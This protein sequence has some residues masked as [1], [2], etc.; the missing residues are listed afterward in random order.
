ML[1]PDNAA[2][3][4]PPRSSA[5][6]KRAK[7]RALQAR[8][9]LKE[10]AAAE[11]AASGAEQQDEFEGVPATRPRSLSMISDGSRGSPT[12][13]PRSG[14]R[15]VRDIAMLNTTI[16][17]QKAKIQTLLSKDTEQQHRI[18]TLEHELDA[19][20]Q[21]LRAEKMRSMLEAKA[22]SDTAAGNTAFQESEAEISRLHKHIEEL[23]ETHKADFAHAQEDADGL[24]QQADEAAAEVEAMRSQIEQLRLILMAQ[25]AAALPADWFERL[26]ARDGGANGGG[27]DDAGGEDATVVA[28][29]EAALEEAY[30]ELEEL[31]SHKGRSNAESSYLSG[32]LDDYE[33][34]ILEQKNEMVRLQEKSANHDKEVRSHLWSSLM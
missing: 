26:M 14:R 19:K 16:K 24:R 20:G 27:D 32:T 7:L 2:D 31:R 1:S 9:A 18:E 22:S 17:N 29:Y 11:E 23:A 25:G 28:E 10:K 33:Q 3:P 21:E 4:A 8:R 15:T 6:E 5:T 34:E 13:S 30:A 12:G